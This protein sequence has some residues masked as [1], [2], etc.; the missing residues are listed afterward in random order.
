MKKWTLVLSSL[1]LATGTVFGQYSEDQFDPNADG[2]VYALAVQPDGSMIV[3]GS[4]TTLGDVARNRIGRILPNGRLDT[5]FDPGAGA[6][7][8]I[9]ALALQSDGKV[10]LGGWISSFAGAVPFAADFD[11]DGLADPAVS[12]NRQWYAWLSSVGYAQV[13]PYAFNL[14]E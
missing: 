9:T 4:F 14:Q 5:T 8:A 7:G 13:G 12:Y 10:V 2:K 6:N 11:G 3:G 1:A